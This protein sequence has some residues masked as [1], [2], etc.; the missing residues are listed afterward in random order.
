MTI[1]RLH[2]SNLRNLSDFSFQPSP[3]INIFYGQNGAGKTSV[4]EAIHLLTHGRSFKSS[5]SRSLIAHDQTEAT[6]F[7]EIASQPGV[8]LPVGISKDKEGKSQVRIGGER[9]SAVSELARLIPV[10]TLNSESFA[11]LEGSPKV[12]RQFLDWGVFHVEQSFLSAWHRAQKALKN[13]NTLL[14]SGNISAPQLVAWDRELVAAANEVD[15][16]RK[17]Y[18]NSFQEQFY[19][20]LNELTD[21]GELSISYQ[22]GWDKT[23]TLAEVLTDSLPRDQ[24]TGFTH[25][26]PQRADLRLRLAKHNAADVLSRGQ[27]KLVVAALKLSQGQNLITKNS[28]RRCVY[29]LDDLP[30]ELDFVHLK[31]ICGVLEE[32]NAQVFISCIEPDAIAECWKDMSRVQMFHVEHGT[33]K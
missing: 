17:R 30:A 33:L 1:H 22:R 6:V 11:L 32:M 13:R 3:G 7:G 23:K 27:Q 24:K 29:L 10:Q 28:Q 21:V 14:R 5:R 4:L 12:R 15:S 25:A 9:V 16:H 31:K 19:S 20:L 26:G 8:S 2:I 18:L